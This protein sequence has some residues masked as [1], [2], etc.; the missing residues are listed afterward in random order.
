MVAWALLMLARDASRPFQA[1]R[2]RPRGVDELGDTQQS[3][4][5]RKETMV[6]ASIKELKS[7]LGRQNVRRR[8]VARPSSMFV[9]ESRGRCGPLAR[10]PLLPPAFAVTTTI[11]TSR[12]RY[13]EIGTVTE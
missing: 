8:C 3:R 13:P 5:L 12:N 6:V 9:R 2:G 10:L 1:V 7:G 11:I 4:E